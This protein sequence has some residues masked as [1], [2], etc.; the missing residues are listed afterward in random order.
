MIIIPWS[1]RFWPRCYQPWRWKWGSGQHC[2]GRPRQLRSSS[3]YFL[4]GL[5]RVCL[6][7][8]SPSPCIIFVIWLGWMSALSIHDISLFLQGQQA[9][10]NK[11]TMWLEWI[12]KKDRVHTNTPYVYAKLDCGQMLQI[13]IKDIFIL[14]VELK[15]CLMNLCYFLWCEKWTEKQ[16]ERKNG[17]VTCKRRS[18]HR[19]KSISH[20]GEG[21]N[22]WRLVW[23][24]SYPVFQTSRQKWSYKSR[25]SPRYRT[26]RR[27][28][29]QPNLEQ[30]VLPRSMQVS[31]SRE[32]QP[33]IFER[34]KWPWGRFLEIEM[35]EDE[36]MESLWLMRFFCICDG[37]EVEVWREEVGDALKRELV[38]ARERKG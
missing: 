21:W 17:N 19:C 38:C 10:G 37:M 4:W 29:H 35:L 15:I 5:C 25:L 3:C 16:R 14:N 23:W 34:E 11:M 1:W 24:W 33:T 18:W 30:Q 12:F 2:R 28:L 13:Q 27:F 31:R 9:R 7:G 6:M 20:Y 32:W 26:N 8:S 22:R 36:F